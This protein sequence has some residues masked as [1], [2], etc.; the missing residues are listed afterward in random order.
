MVNGVLILVLHHVPATKMK[1]GRVSRTPLKPITEAEALA[2]VPKQH[3]LSPS[4]SVGTLSEVSGDWVVPIDSH[5]IA[6][7]EASQGFGHE[8]W[9]S[10]G[11]PHCFTAFTLFKFSTEPAR[12]V[13]ANELEGEKGCFVMAA[14][15]VTALEVV[16]VV[17]RKSREIFQLE[18][19]DT[20]L[21]VTGS[22]RIPVFPRSSG[23]AADAPEDKPAAKLQIGDIVMIG[24]QGGTA[25]RELTEVVVVKFE[26]GNACDVFEITFSP[27]Q[28]VAVFPQ[29]GETLLSN[30]FKK[31]KV[32]TAP[33]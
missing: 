13:P 2:K 25:K 9:I 7:S 27:D 18:A 17:P 14:D 20:K 10:Q 12:F 5:S 28:P 16:S 6:H 24:T 30:G 31:K 11:G 29:F 33:P 32:L 22:H 23:I 15:G 26:Q 19:G 4:P 21:V 1:L 3:I 8:S